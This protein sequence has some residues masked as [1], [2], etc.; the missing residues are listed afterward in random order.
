MENYHKIEARHSQSSW[1]KAEHV[2][3][4]KTVENT[5]NFGALGNVVSAHGVPKICNYVHDSSIYY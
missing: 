2:S 5:D 3:E 4:R 1:Y